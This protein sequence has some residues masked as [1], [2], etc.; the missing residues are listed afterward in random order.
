MDVKKKKIIIRVVI[1][2]AA[3]MCAAAG[4]VAYML[5][6]NQGISYNEVRDTVGTGMPET[7]GQ[8]KEKK[9]PEIPIDFEEL[10][11]INSEAYAWITVPG[12][13]IDY[14][15]LRSGQD[16]AYYLNHTIDKKASPEGSIYTEDYN[17][18]DF[19]DTNTLIY[20]H[21]M[22]NGTLFGSLQEYR[23]KTYFDEHNTM[24]IYTPDAVRTYR[25]FAAYLYDNRHILQSFDFDD[26]IVFDKYLR[27]IFAMREMN[28]CVDTNAEV[29]AD[30]KII[31]LS[32]C[33]GTQN[34]RRFLVQAVL[35]SIDK[36]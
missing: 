27:E 5:W 14:P 32:T 28:S 18:K 23:D 34:D 10:Q 20:G 6:K 30:D 33:Y 21:N 13:K 9:A 19:E 12:T 4:I 3:A 22:R 24:L 26:K 29:G 2:L 31:T 1:C 25:V 11:K 17:S 8:P 36:I 16:N 35:V 7:D 15:I